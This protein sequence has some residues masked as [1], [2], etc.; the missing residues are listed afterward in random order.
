MSGG[1]SRLLMYFLFMVIIAVA[2]GIFFFLQYSETKKPGESCF[3]GI[4]CTGCS[5]DY[6]SI[7]DQHTCSCS[8][9]VRLQ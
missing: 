2:L 3:I 6:L 7:C 4:Q 8:Y 9:P 5:K 1:A